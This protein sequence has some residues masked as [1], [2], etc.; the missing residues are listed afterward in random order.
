MRAGVF[1]QLK[2][3]EGD[4]D[5]FVTLSKKE[6]DLLRSHPDIMQKYMQ[7]GI[8]NDIGEENSRMWGSDWEQVA[9]QNPYLQKNASIRAKL[10]N[11][12]LQ[13]K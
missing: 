13:G 1:P 7:D 11:A 10:I 12:A 2:K 3:A 6:Y 8:R 9:N 4:E 5:D